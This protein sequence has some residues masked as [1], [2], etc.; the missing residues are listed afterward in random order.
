MLEEGELPPSSTSGENS[1]GKAGEMC[2]AQALPLGHGRAWFQFR[3]WVP[4]T[5]PAPSPV[6]DKM[7]RF[8]GFRGEAT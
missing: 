5:R 8:N 1:P 3:R 7:Q 4:T 6:Y 2:G